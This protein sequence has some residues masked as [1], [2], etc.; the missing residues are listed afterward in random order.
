MCG[1]QRDEAELPFPH[2]GRDAF[3][4][5]VGDR[6]VF[7]VS[8]PDDDIGCIQRGVVE[9]LLE[10]VKVRSPYSYAG[11][12][13]E[14]RGDGL[15]EKLVSISLFLLRLLFIPNQDADRFRIGGV[16]L[17]S[18]AFSSGLKRMPVNID[19]TNTPPTRSSV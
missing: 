9:A 17:K 15:P 6:R 14:M 11:L 12:R 7:D 10:R 18:P 2:T 13:G 19:L 4:M 3:G 16:N 5:G 1:V 8:P